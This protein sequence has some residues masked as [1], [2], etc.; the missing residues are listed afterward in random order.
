MKAIHLILP[1]VMLVAWACTREPSPSSSPHPVALD[2]TPS[3]SPASPVTRQA[4]VGTGGV[5]PGNSTFA[6]WICEHHAGSYTDGSNPYTEY[7]LRY[8]NIQASRSDAGWSYNYYGYTGFPTLYILPKDDDRNGVTDINADIFAYSPYQAS[9]TPESVPFTIAGAVDVMYAA[10]NGVDNLDIDPAN[11][12]AGPRY[13]PDGPLGRTLQVPL[14]FT[15][16][17]AL[18]EFEFRLRNS[19]Y[20]H[21]DGDS[22][23]NPYTLDYIR[24]RRSVGGHPLYVS[25][26]MNAMRGGEL[27]GL[28]PAADDMLT[29][30]GAAL[31]P[32]YND[33]S[34]GVYPD[35]NQ[36]V[37]AKAYLLQ[38]PSQ[39]G[40][41]YAD[42]DYTFEFKFSGQEFPVTFTLLT[43]HLKSSGETEFSGFRAGTKYTFHFVIDNYVHFEGL[44]VGEWETVEEPIHQSEI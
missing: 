22:T 40:D 32:L 42:G 35:P 23:A 15:H 17:L 44:P 10:E 24:I 34:L 7:A 12:P 26:T 27:S 2:V 28:V 19:E 38:V 9:A 18:L 33:R 41:T 30:S 13:N 5:M 36:P 25:G 31:R 29:V 11:I 37:P 4:I 14:T 6:L 8:N 20:N 39:T 3:L 1:A 21:P 16:A 43:D